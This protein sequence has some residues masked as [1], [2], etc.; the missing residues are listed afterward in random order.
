MSEDTSLLVLHNN[1]RNGDEISFDSYNK[2][3]L[4]ELEKKMQINEGQTMRV[5]AASLILKLQWK[6]MPSGI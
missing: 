3:R 4:A 6:E 2:E 1:L 5:P